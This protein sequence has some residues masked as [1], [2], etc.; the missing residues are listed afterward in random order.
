VRL[1]R[2][3]RAR[4]LILVAAARARFTLTAR[5]LH[6]VCDCAVELQLLARRTA[7]PLTVAR[8]LACLTREGHRLTWPACLRADLTNLCIVPTLVARIALLATLQWLEPASGTRF[9]G[10][11]TTRVGIIA[12]SAG[13]ACRGATQAPQSELAL[14]ALRTLR[15]T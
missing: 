2:L 12:R 13:G 9:A 7:R 14:R 10:S 1:A 15:G 3:A 5:G 4:L 11:L 8:G 6:R